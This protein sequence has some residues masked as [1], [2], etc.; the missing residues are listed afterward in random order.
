[1]DVNDLFGE[2]GSEDYVE[3]LGAFFGLGQGE[4]TWLK[5]YVEEGCTIDLC[6]RVVSS[7]I[8]NKAM[9]LVVA[10]PILGRIDMKTIGTTEDIIAFEVD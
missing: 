10:N 6:L 4:I 9:S 7:D 1:M 3:V 5:Q 8:N 2:P